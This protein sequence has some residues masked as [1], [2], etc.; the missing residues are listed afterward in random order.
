MSYIQIL[1]EFLNSHKLTS[2]QIDGFNEC[3]KYKIPK[4]IEESKLEFVKNDS[5]HFL[6]FHNVYISKPDIVD[7]NGVRRDLYPSECRDRMM[8]YSGSVLVDIVHEIKKDSKKIS[9]ETY[10]SVNIGKLPIMIGSDWCHLKGLRSE[11]LIKHLECA[12]DPG[13]YFL[14]SGKEYALLSQ[15]RMAHNEI[16]VFKNNL[17]TKTTITAPNVRNGSRNKEYSHHAI[18]RSFNENCEPNISTTTVMISV[19]NIERGEEPLIYCSIPGFKDDIPLVVLF[20]ALNVPISEIE[21]YILGGDPDSSLKKLLQPSL[22]DFIIDTHIIKTQQDAI[23]YL[24]SFVTTQRE[25]KVESVHYFLK[26]RFLQNMSDM[27]LKIHNISHMIYLLLK[28]AAG[29]REPDDRD[30]YAKKR[31]ETSGALYNNL[32]RSCWKLISREI[33]GLLEKK[34]NMTVQTVYDNKITTIFKKAVETGNWT[35]TKIAKNVKTG[36]S[37]S[38][39]RHNYVSTVS[40]LRRVITPSDKNS[41][42]IKPRFL[43]PSH[44]YYLCPFETPEG[45][46]TGLHKNLSLASTITLSSSDEIIYDYLKRF[47]TS[48]IIDGYPSDSEFD[49]SRSKIFVNGQLIAFADLDL[50]ELASR[51]IE[52]RRENKISRDVSISVI[53]ETLRIYTDEGRLTAPYIRLNVYKDA[54]STLK[55]IEGVVSWASFLDNGIVEYLDISECETLYIG[56]LPWSLEKNMTHSFIHPALIAGASASSCPF[57]NCNQSPRVIYQSSMCKQ[58]LGIPAL[59]INQRND[60]TAYKLLSPHRPLIESRINK[61][62]GCSDLPNG[63]NLVVAI[64]SYTGN[65]QEDSLLFN[66]DSVDMGML[67]S[68]YYSSYIESNHRKGTVS[69]EI[70]LPER[71]NV[72]ETRQIGYSKLDSDGLPKENTPLQKR[73]VVVGKVLYTNDNVKDSSVII[74]VNGLNDDAVNLVSDT[75]IVDPVGSSFVDRVLLTTDDDSNKTAIVRTRQQRVPQIGNKCACMKSGT[76]QALTTDGWKFI[77]EITLQDKVA[78]LKDGFVVY[79]NPT[80]LHCYDYDGDLYELKT[81]QVELTVTP[82]HRM[83]VSNIFSDVYDFK[84]AEELYMK[85]VNYLTCDENMKLKIVKYTEN[86]IYSEKWVP[87]IGKVYC[88]SVPSEVFYVRQNGKG[89]WSGNSRSAQKGI[90]GLGLSREDMPQCVKTGITPNIVMNPTGFPSR[91]TISQPKEA[92]KSLLCCIKGEVGDGTAF[93]NS[94]EN[95]ENVKNENE[96][97]CS[98]VYKIEEEL[99]KD[100]ENYGLCKWGDTQM[101]SGITGEIMNAKIYMCPTYY[102]ALR[103]MVDDKIHARSQNGPRDILSMQPID[104]RRR[105]GGFRVGEMECWAGISHGASNFLIDRLVNNSDSYEYY[106]CDDCGNSVVADITNNN[107]HCRR[108]DQS[109]RI[110]KVVIPYGFKLMQQE[111]MATGIGVWVEV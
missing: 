30:H 78:T 33:K 86:D 60:T 49:N 90:L 70:K 41:R 92:L 69:T 65:N 95:S 109:T 14:T 66:K 13:G 27:Q 83:W 51:F 111:L 52:L 102:Q 63:Q 55:K 28:T 18:V 107:Y 81:Q 74:K 76:T 11:D 57:F 56:V 46:K 100:L 82:N 87:Y 91:M 29:I 2:H 58:G 108:C 79:E 94:F 44:F 22:T 99:E 64:A 4:T 40:N 17:K 105:G 15:D 106:V 42:V 38:L 21:G 6:T 25:K 24:A 73:D 3:L 103:H 71:L 75:F 110:S 62:I 43:H 20:I 61:L 85:Y 39:N 26:Y 98:D 34:K 47:G 101:I 8:S 7:P 10:S 19:D 37:D 97:D 1:K 96:W 36:V 104:G 31:I 35:A 53:D 5:Q 50:Y 54:K 89:V 9:S 12:R 16:F 67:R 93:E 32:F 23:N 88:L 77:E 68:F 84:T 45:H 80:E 48:L 72:K 59:N